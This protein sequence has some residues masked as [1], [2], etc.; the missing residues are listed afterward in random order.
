MQT[1]CNTILRCWE[2]QSDSIEY[3]KTLRRPGLWPGP[4]WGAYNAPANP[5]LVGRG[6]PPPQEPHQTALGPSG[7]EW[8][9]KLYFTIPC[10]ASPTPP[11]L[12]N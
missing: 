7:V 2:R 6:W 4:R 8:D 12:Q 3:K 5:Y 10:L 9:V 11:P 1:A